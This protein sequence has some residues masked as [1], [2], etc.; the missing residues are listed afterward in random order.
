MEANE[1]N[2]TQ[3]QTGLCRS[4]GFVRI[5]Y[6]ITLESVVWRTAHIGLQFINLTLQSTGYHGRLYT[7]SIVCARR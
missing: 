1:L 4:V 5:I 7:V 2:V 6:H 3:H